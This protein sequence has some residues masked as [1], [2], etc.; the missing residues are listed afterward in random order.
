MLKFS[1]ELAQHYSLCM[2]ITFEK[3]WNEL[4]PKNRFNLMY[5][6]FP[7]LKGFLQGIQK[8]FNDIF[9]EIFRI[10]FYIII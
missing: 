7:L 9:K 5:K 3:V 2:M 1:N 4:I 6:M 10:H 8:N